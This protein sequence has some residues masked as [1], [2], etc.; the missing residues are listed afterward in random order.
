MQDNVYNITTKGYTPSTDMQLIAM[1]SVAHNTG[2]GIWFYSNHQKKVGNW[3]SGEKAFE[4]CENLGS[5][6]FIEVLQNY[7]HSS[8][9]TYITTEE[10][11]NLY[12]KVFSDSITN[13]TTNT[14]N[15]TFPIKSLYAYIKL[16][17]LYTE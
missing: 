16:S 9:R 4:L 7:A 11:L 14:T 2:S 12:S 6:E 8:E 3:I 17:E 5:T 15:G 10:A 1:L 13:Y